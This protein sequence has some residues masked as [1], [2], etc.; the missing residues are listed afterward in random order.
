MKS[1]RLQ[2][3]TASALDGVLTKKDLDKHKVL[4]IPANKSLFLSEL[5]AKSDQDFK[6]EI[7][8][9][10]TNISGKTVTQITSLPVNMLQRLAAKYVRQAKALKQ[11]NRQ[12]I[13]SNLINVLEEGTP[14]RVVKMD[15][16]DFYGSLNAT[17][18]AD[19]VIT[20]P[21]I[22]M[23][24]SRV[25][26]NLLSHLGPGLPRGLELSAVLAEYQMTEFDEKIRSLPGTFFYARFV[27]D[28]VII[29][30]DQKSYDSLVSEVEK[31]LPVGATLNTKKQK[32]FDIGRAEKASIVPGTLG[33]LDYL[34]YN[35][36]ILNPDSNPKYV[37]RK[38][39]VD[40][41]QSKRNRFKSKIC[42]AA[43]DYLK[44]KDF[45]LFD[46]RMRILSNNYRFYDHQSKKYIMTGLSINYFHV[47]EKAGGGFSEIDAFTRGLL[48]SGNTKLSMA[49]RDSLTSRQKVALVKKS[50][51]HGYQRRTFCH[52][53]SSRIEAI[54][55]VWRYV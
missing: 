34:G 36:K 37:R 41:S 55:S 54:R 2:S 27:D 12:L 51:A 8:K 16:R 52:F 18:I 44:N 32:T 26:C 5:A 17:H 10:E 29:I 42:L 6:G 1:R 25:V 11:S 47:T 28:I 31:S 20:D 7:A 35:I 40:V 46:D 49:L 3:F 22:S 38:V 30:D 19:K 39:K 24:T 53:P 23:L 45:V 43:L 9:S 48:F 50:F 14:Y 13:V 33:Q 15:L 21:D 4:N